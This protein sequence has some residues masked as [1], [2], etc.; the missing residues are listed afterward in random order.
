MST[1]YKESNRESAFELFNKT[2]IYKSEAL[3]L[4]YPNLVDFSFA[5]KALYGKVNRDYI[6][7]ISDPGTANFKSFI[8]VGNP[9]QNLQALAFVVDA[10]E[11]LAQQFRK[12]TQT[13]K[14]YSNDPNLSNLK[15]FKSYKSNEISYNEYQT[16]FIQSLLDNMNIDNITNF[17]SFT[18]RLLSTVNR[19]TKTFP[20]SRPAYI[21]SRFNSLTNTGF[22][23]EI[24][25]ADFNNDE[26][27][28][29]EFIN[30]K[31]WEFYVNACNSYGF[32]IDI[33]APWRLIADLDSEVMLGYANRYGLKSTDLVLTLGF[34]TTHGSYYNS[35]PQQL[36]SLY[37][38]MIPT[39][40]PTYD[41][42]GAKIVKPEQYSLQ[43]LRKKYSNKFFLT[44]YFNLR[45]SEEESTFSETHRKKIIDDCLQ[46]SKTRGDAAAV[47]IFETFINQPFDYRG[48]LSY[49]SF[50]NKLREDQ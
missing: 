21:K 40:I 50:A 5:E 22:A 9:Q 3:K 18:K 43:D 14:I 20:M 17:H 37:N 31:N 47:R 16:I 42:C 1:F 11:D 15:A 23:V 6:P 24:A 44:F 36:L 38:Q 41:Q 30:S 35:L 27:K 4:D 28:I 49:I 34:R 10:F 25:E 7:V 13:G 26:Q 39:H 29:L 45:F 19:V 32:M 46:I 8:S 12:A 33:N 48:S 2:I